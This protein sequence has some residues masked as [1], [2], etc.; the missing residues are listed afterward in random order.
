[1]A[2]THPCDRRKPFAPWKAD[3]LYIDD[4]GRI[5]CGACQGIEST[6]KPWAFSDLGRMGPDRSV[7]RPAERVEMGPG[8]LVEV[9]SRTY[10]C[11]LDPAA[12]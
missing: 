7:T 8:R 9:E 6:Y 2:S 10:R 5:L 3:H 12:P 1:M 11:E 4:D